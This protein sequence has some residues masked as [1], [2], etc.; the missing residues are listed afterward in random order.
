[1]PTGI[2]PDA[3]PPRMYWKRRGSFRADAP[4]S[5]TAGPEHTAGDVDGVARLLRF[6][7]TVPRHSQDSF[8]AHGRQ[9]AVLG[10][11]SARTAHSMKECASIAASSA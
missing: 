10:R 9:G 2:D 7:D 6:V 8:L 4:G 5:S 11:E 1:M 3:A